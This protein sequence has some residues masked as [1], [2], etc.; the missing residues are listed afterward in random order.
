MFCDATFSNRSSI[1]ETTK[2][3]FR[4]SFRSTHSIGMCFTVSGHWQYWYCKLSNMQSKAVWL[5]AWVGYSAAAVYCSTWVW[6]L[7]N[8]VITETV[9]VNTYPLHFT[10]FDLPSFFIVF[11]IL[12]HNRALYLCGKCMV[13]SCSDTKR[14]VY[15]GRKS[16]KWQIV[17]FA[18]NP[19]T[20]CLTSEVTGQVNCE[21]WCWSESSE[22]TAGRQRF[23]SQLT[24]ART[25]S[26]WVWCMGPFR[27]RI[28]HYVITLQSSFHWTVRWF[29]H[30]VSMTKCKL[31][32][33]SQRD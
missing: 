23:S 19:D 18:V 14:W 31:D 6:N 22:H 21:M 12:H 17:M 16:G 8:S 2:Y 24:A 4:T 10:D 1:E 33:F 29:V 25:L 9:T 26:D 27:H 15:V 5:A 7:T 20:Y 11:K 28:S 30:F 32:F 13:I 3:L